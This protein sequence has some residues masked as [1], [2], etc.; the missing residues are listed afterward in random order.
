MATNDPELQGLLEGYFDGRLSEAETKRLNERLRQDPAARAAYREAADWHAAFSTWGEQHAG[1]EAAREWRDSSE[2]VI[3]RPRNFWRRVLPLAAV[4]ALVVVGFFTWQMRNSSEALAKLT[5]TQHAEWTG[6]APRNGLELR[7]RSYRLVS[8]VIRFETG[9]GAVVTV[10]GPADF[11]FVADD[12]IELRRGKLTAR[13]LRD[14]SRLTVKV[15]EMEVRDLGTAFGVDANDVERTLVSVFDG[16][17]AVTSRATPGQEL[18]L[19]EGKSFVAPRDTS[20]GATPTA[21]DPESF[22]DLWPLTVGINEASRLVE[23]LPPGPLLKPMREYRANDR[24]FLFPERQNVLT[25][26]PVDIDLSGEAP[27][28]PDSP[29][30]PYPLPRG[31]RVD[32]YLVF[33]QPEIAR[34]APRQL[35]GEITFQRPVLGVIC[36]D[37]G[38]DRSDTVLGHEAANYLAPGQRRGLEEADKEHYRGDSLPHDSLRLS[39]DRRTLYFDFYVSNE[40]EQV[41]VLV[42]SH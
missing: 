26:R 20:S 24:L 22:R 27:A 1:G 4:A 28:W 35:K 9:A 7:R 38:L 14:E 19:G 40:R 18:R 21:Y 33:F 2:T 25:E 30:S 37:Y 41:R 11:D 8:G 10:S 42:A 12:R 13:M 3:I 17:V 32:S 16:L 6:E 34:G 23:F 39:A 31:E 15:G 5:F 36:S 29:A